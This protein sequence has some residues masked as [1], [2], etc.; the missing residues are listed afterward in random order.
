[1][2]AWEALPSEADRRAAAPNL[3]REALIFF[4][5]ALHKDFGLHRVDRALSRLERGR[6]P[7]DHVAQDIDEALTA[8][9]EAAVPHPT[10]QELRDRLD[11][12]ERDS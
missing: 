7:L 9:Y 2:A 4:E 1:M 6:G 8:Y 10:P 5:G 12:L 11:L 3:V